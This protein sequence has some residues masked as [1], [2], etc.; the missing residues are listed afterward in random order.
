MTISVIMSTYHRERAEYLDEAMQSIWTDQMRKPDEIVLI[1]DGPL[2]PELDK[3]VAQWQQTIGSRLVVRCKEKN[4]GLAMALNEAIAMSHGELLARMDSDDISMPNRFALQEK[5]ME[6]H[7]EV[8]ILGGSL[9]EFNDEG[10]LDKVRIYPASASD[11][12]HSMHRMS[13]L[14]HPSVM[15]RRRFFDAGFRYSNRYPICEDV[16]LWYD[17]VCAGR[18]IHNIPD[19]ILRFR[20]NEGAMHRRSKQ[21]A[22]SEFR[23]Y[24]NGIYRLCGPFSTRYV[25]SFARLLFRLMPLPLIKWVYRGDGLRNRLAIL[26]GFLL[27]SNVL[28]G[29]SYLTP[30]QVSTYPDLPLLEIHTA[31]GI[32]PTYTVI[33][34]PTGCIGKG[35]TN[36][37]YV[38]GNLKLWKDG[39]V[40]YMTGDSTA[41]T[42]GMKLKV[43]GNSSAA[44][45][46]MHPYKIKL[47]QK[48][49]LFLSGNTSLAAKEFILLKTNVWNTH[50]TDEENDLLPFVDEA[51]SALLGCPWTP[52]YEMVN[53]V[54]NGT[55]RGCYVMAD[56][57]SRG[58]GRI[59]IDKSGFIIE[60]DPYWWN[61]DGV[62]F[63]TNHLPYPMGYTFKYPDNDDVTDSIKHL[64]ATYMNAVE[65]AIWQGDASGYIDYESF[66]TWMLVHEILGTDD[67]AGSNI[68]LY[69]ESF[70]ATDFQTGLLKMGPTWDLDTSFRRDSTQFSSIHTDNAFYFLQIFQIPAFDSIYISKWNSVKGQVY[71]TVENHL[72]SLADAHQE[73]IDSSLVR[74]RAIYGQIGTSYAYQEVEILARLRSRLNNLDTK[75][76][77]RGGIN[78]L[79]DTQKA[80]IYDIM[81]RR[82]SAYSTLPHGIYIQN[83]KRFII[84]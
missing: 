42:Y 19:V 3:V 32:D 51:L 26:I 30:Q 36:N 68:F 76:N 48:A 21:K 65:A 33:Y 75:I 45:G 29:Q 67:P 66:A 79:N 71:T 50:F 38:Q 23:A 1:E 80:N 14:G 20:R 73:A 60:D 74:S 12:R 18:I 56:A 53:V 24:N 17:A 11:V 31:A 81:G 72:D 35:I 58:E 83:R 27:V 44:S 34:P 9:R 41:T 28:I 63:K 57:V 49:D 55:Y 78:S 15:F 62:Y 8:D 40:A 70:S 25:Y 46:D 59:N 84:K 82:W 69:R 13:P 52:R 61:E 64:Y 4:E 10:T 54:M 7:P 16:V 47:A 6:E 43:R 39:R 2:T 37:E 5:Y 77:Q 22:W